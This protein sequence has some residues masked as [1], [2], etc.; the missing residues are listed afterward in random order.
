MRTRI[1][2]GTLLAL[3]LAAL[4]WLDLNPN[5]RGAPLCLVAMALTGAALHEFFAM[6]R[7]VDLSPFRLTGLGFGIVLLP[8]YVWAEELKVLLGAQAMTAFLIAPLLLLILALMARAYTR[9]EGFGPQLKNIAVTLFGVLY[10]AVPMAFLIL[11]RFLTEKLHSGGEGWDLVM[12][13]VAVTKASDVGAYFTGTLI[14]RHKLAPK[15]SPNKTVEGAVG[16][17]LTSALVAV[18]MVYGMNIHTLKDL[19]HGLLATISFGIIIGVASQI[20]DLTESFIKRGTNIKDSGN[21]LPSFGGVLDLIDSFLI[22]APV[23]YF[24][25]AIFAKVTVRAATS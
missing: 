2:F 18:I 9:P 16:G 1:F 4:L 19:G 3:A 22:A 14:G 15:V 17:L 25:L 10:I 11:T 8:Y 12:L 13:V 23:A 21:L 6:V 20:G 5:W 7:N 24:V